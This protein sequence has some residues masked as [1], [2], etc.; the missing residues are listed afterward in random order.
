MENPI[1]YVDPWSGV[2]GDMLL[3]AMLDTDREGGRLEA[4]FRES[5]GALAL[6]GTDVDIVRDM[7]RGVSCTRVKVDD[8]GA[9][10]LRHLADMELIIDTAGLS[11]TVRSRSMKAVRRLAEVEA[12]VH[13]CSVDEIHFHEVGAVDTLVDV[14][15]TFALVEA[16]G[17]ARV[18]VGPIPV[19]G[20]YVEIAHGRMGVPA[21]ATTRLLHGYDLVGGPEMRELTTPTGAL[22]VGELGATGG[23]IPPMRI[24]R[25]GYGAGCMTLEGGPNVLRVLVG[26]ASQGG[27]TDA[28]RD[29]VSNEQVVELQTNLDDVS[30]EVIGHACGV[31]RD[32]GALDVWVVPASMKK[33]RPGVVLHAL[34][35]GE[36]EM[37]VTTSIFEETG[38]LGVRR[39]MTERHTAERGVTSVLVGA[40]MV[41]V[42]WGR[43]QDRLV[44]LA[45]EYEDAAAVAGTTGVPLKD[46]MRLAVAIARE[47]LGE[48]S[49][50]GALAE[51]PETGR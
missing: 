18:M 17:I 26:R 34:V 50:S 20:G 33:G 35:E 3:A 47:E 49:L 19:G 5:V 27:V 45:P 25:V 30:P 4:V 31:L 15:G 51:P 43:W 29:G 48:T 41:R 44:S 7:E 32:G 12:A 37:A 28:V 46:V 13:G 16:L 2:S 9:P 11:E 24:E 10:P 40:D 6:E 14:V 38:T 21:P 23:P 42:K 39:R 22:L 36:K 1:L 8:G